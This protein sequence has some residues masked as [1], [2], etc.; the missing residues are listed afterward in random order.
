MAPPRILELVPPRNTR[1]TQ[2]T[3][4]L[5]MSITMHTNTTLCIYIL[6]GHNCAPRNTCD[7]FQIGTAAMSFQNHDSLSFLDYSLHKISQILPLT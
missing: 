1:E 3:I 6:H 7:Y 4:L 5:R 2:P